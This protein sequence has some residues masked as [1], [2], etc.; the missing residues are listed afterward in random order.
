MDR[1]SDES[2]IL[3]ERYAGWKNRNQERFTDA[4]PTEGGEPSFKGTLYPGE[5]TLHQHYVA[6]FKYMVERAKALRVSQGESS[7]RFL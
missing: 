6:G 3:R 2:W 4:I 7:V 1:D 5:I